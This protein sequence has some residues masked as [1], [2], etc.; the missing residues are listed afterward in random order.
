MSN[1]PPFLTSKSL[2]SEGVAHGFFGRDG[3]VSNGIFESL[4][5]GLASTDD[6]DAV[7]ENRSRCARALGGA[8]MPLLTLQ[9]IHSPDVVVVENAWENGAP[10]ADAMVTNRPNIV[11]GVLAADCMPW[12]FVDA[13]AGIIGAAHAGWRGA[14]AGVLEATVSAMVD[15]GASASNISAAVGPA[16]RQ[17]NFEV[18]L[19]LVEQFLSKYPD[20]DQFFTPGVSDEK[21]QFNLITFGSWRLS[22]M[23]VTAI[24]DLDICTLDAPKK[25]FSYRDANNNQHADYGRNLSAITLL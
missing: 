3:G 20:T 10:K 9:Q 11:L 1:T 13:K 16:L 15:L 17:R 24:D 6:P 21:K 22:E 25:Y 19:D 7:A 12:L 23:D 5:V 2:P 4:N 8:K 18:G 14:L